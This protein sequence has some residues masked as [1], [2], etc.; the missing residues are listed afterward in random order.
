MGQSSSSTEIVD[1]LPKCVSLDKVSVADE[2]LAN[3][4]GSKSSYPALCRSISTNTT[5]STAASS[6]GTYSH[7]RSMQTDSSENDKESASSHVSSVSEGALDD[8][9][10]SPCKD[11]LSEASEESSS[12]KDTVDS[13]SAAPASD[14]P[15]QSY[16]PEFPQLFSRSMAVRHTFIHFD[17]PTEDVSCRRNLSAPPSLSRRYC[18]AIGE[19]QSSACSAKSRPA[20]LE[21]L[22]IDKVDILNAGFLLAS[23]LVAP[24]VPSAPPPLNAPS[25]N[26]PRI[27]TGT[28]VEIDGLLRLPHFNG[29]VGVVQSFDPDTERYDVAVLAADGS[30]TTRAKVKGVNLRYRA[31]PPPC[32]AP[33]LSTD[34]DEPDESCD[35]ASSMPTTPRWEE[36][37]Q[38]VGSWSE[39]PGHGL[40]LPAAS[41]A[42][43][44]PMW[45]DT[46][47]VIG[48]WGD[49][50]HGC[51][52]LLSAPPPSGWWVDDMQASPAYGEWQCKGR[53]YGGD[54]Y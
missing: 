51:S 34:S 44:A 42:P 21:K 20:V 23:K 28:E 50:Q 10:P 49:V 3:E 16:H 29:L 4:A 8:E 53:D 24:A 31:P 32:F 27:P 19:Q 11:D 52:D 7:L 30:N 47:Q 13:M 54:I 41:N 5:N 38:A 26:L 6:E 39:V 14:S 33:T 1:S 48:T 35:S 2:S 12:T 37:V 15:G 17:E 46:A 36:E 22:T 18:T 25:I 9:L 43:V 45:E 40:L